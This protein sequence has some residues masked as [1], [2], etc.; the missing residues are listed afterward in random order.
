MSRRRPGV[1]FDPDGAVHEFDSSHDADEDQATAVLRELGI[2]G[3]N[4][5]L[6]VASH[7]EVEVAAAMRSGNINRGVLV[8]NRTTGVCSAEK[9]GCMEVVPQVLPDGAQLTV[10]SPKEIAAGEPIVFSKDG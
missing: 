1:F 3:P 7:V 2:V 4:A 6:T 10:W 9:F 8:I 5:T